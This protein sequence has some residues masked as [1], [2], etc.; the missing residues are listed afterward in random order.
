M[1]IF[2]GKIVVKSYEF[3]QTFSRRAPTGCRKLCKFH[4]GLRLFPQVYFAKQGKSIF[5]RV[6]SKQN[7]GGSFPPFRLSWNMFAAGRTLHFRT[8]EPDKQFGKYL[9]KVILLARARKKHIGERVV[10]SCLWFFM[11]KGRGKSLNL[12]LKQN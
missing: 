12:L 3:D 2:L 8:V 6:E 11:W 4:H 10:I 7:D 5:I 9:A 1:T